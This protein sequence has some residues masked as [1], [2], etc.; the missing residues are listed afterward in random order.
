MYAAHLHEHIAVGAV[1]GPRTWRNGEPFVDPV[2]WYLDNG[3]DEE[4]MERLVGRDE[5]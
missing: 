4:L 2:T 5:Q 1:L 3:V